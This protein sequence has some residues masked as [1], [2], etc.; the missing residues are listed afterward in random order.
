MSSVRSEEQERWRAQWAGPRGWL[1]A[2]LLL[3]G[4]LSF[5]A[6]C[7]VMLELGGDATPALGLR[8]L[9]LVSLALLLGL[10]PQKGLRWL[11]PLL[12]VVGSGEALL[13]LYRL[14]LL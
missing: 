11:L 8:A 3:T 1:R 7:L 13:K 10:Y 9:S 12:L 14:V 5:L 2:G 4:V 6:W